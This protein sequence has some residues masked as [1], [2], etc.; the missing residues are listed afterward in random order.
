M[1]VLSTPAILLTLLTTTG[2]SQ[3]PFF[4]FEENGPFRRRWS[5]AFR[6]HGTGR[7]VSDRPFHIRVC[8]Q[9]ADTIRMRLSMVRIFRLG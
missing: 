5:R 9:C 8:G 1:R 2:W 6:Q 3:A 4:P 7:L